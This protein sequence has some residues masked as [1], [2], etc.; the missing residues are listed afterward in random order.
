MLH[1]IF[2][3][4]NKIVTV[5]DAGIQGGFGSAI[6]EFMIDNNY[7]ARIIRLGIPDRFIEHGEQKELYHECGFDTKAI[8]DS[9]RQ[10]AGEAVEAVLAE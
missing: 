1:K 8:M 6:G 4:F 10:M 2:K 5:E 7:E 9:V 3:K